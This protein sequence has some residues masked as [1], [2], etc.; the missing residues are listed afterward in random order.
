MPTKK[1]PTASKP[2]SK[3]AAKPVITSAKKPM[4]G[5]PYVLGK[6]YM[7]RGATMNNAGKLVAVFANEL[8]LDCAVWVADSGRY[9]KFLQAPMETAI[10]VEAYSKPV[11]IP[12]SSIIDVT[13]IPAFQPVTK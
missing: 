2:A 7:V 11:I 5:T 9:H 10:E 6:T 1:K 3:P 4:D 8:V 12:R 13:E